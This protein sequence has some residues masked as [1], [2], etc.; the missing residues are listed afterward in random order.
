MADHR[1]LEVGIATLVCCGFYEA[2]PQAPLLPYRLFASRSL[3]LALVAATV[4]GLIVYPT[5]TY[6]P[7]FFQFVKLQTSLQSAVSM[8][9]SCCG[10]IVFA[11]L[12][13]VVVE[14]TQQYTWQLW[15]SWVFIVVG[16]GLFS[17]M[18]VS[19]SVAK[20]AGVQIIV[21]VGL[22][23][24][25]TVL[26][27]AMQA[28][29]AAVEDQS[30]AVG[31]LVAF[32]LFGALVVLAIGSTVFA[33][34]FERSLA[35]SSSSGMIGGGALPSDVVD[36]LASS[37]GS[38]ALVPRLQDLLGE[39]L[40]SS[41]SEVLR[42]MIRVYSETWQTIWYVTAALGCLGF[43]ASWFIRESSIDTEDLGRQ[44]I[45]DGHSKEETRV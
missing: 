17:R 4:H 12:S 29:A 3:A 22:G 36:A 6:V 27:L 7:L 42:K 43:A 26:P 18:D 8:L 30:L 13:G 41:P 9:P 34:V 21:G 33:S 15:A 19:S 14:V 10:V 5:T 11:L 35:S 2:K 23:A 28:D 24:L 25:F 20:T 37:S 44:H 31:I 1:A 39:D 40:S 38:L 45:Q 16:M 32:R